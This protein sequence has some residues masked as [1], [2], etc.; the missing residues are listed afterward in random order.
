MT[1]SETALLLCKLTV[2]ATEKQT[3]QPGSLRMICIVA[4]KNQLFNQIAE[5]SAYEIGSGK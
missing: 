2:N 3:K 5:K 4:Q 1:Q